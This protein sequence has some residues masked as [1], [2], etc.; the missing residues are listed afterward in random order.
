MS[1]AGNTLLW[2]GAFFALSFGA[3][4]VV[5]FADKMRSGLMGK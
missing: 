2:A 3:I 1:N 5:W 4:F